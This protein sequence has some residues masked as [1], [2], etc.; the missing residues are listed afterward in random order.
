[1]VRPLQ[2]PGFLDRI[3]LWI[4][5]SPVMWSFLLF[6]NLFSV[7]YMLWEGHDPHAFDPY[8]FTFLNLILAIFVAEMDIL[9]VIAQLVSAAKTDH[10]IE[11]ISEMVHQ[12]DRRDAAIQEI[13]ENSLL[14][15]QS[16]RQ[17]AEQE[18]ARDAEVHRILLE[19]NARGERLEALIQLCPNLCQ[20][21]STDSSTPPERNV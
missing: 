16:L 11:T 14:A 13:V 2:K 12:N 7:T 10:V 4:F 18:T 9:I 5:R 3:A 8:P 15:M 17:M 1:M 20:T 21:V 6:F 19:G